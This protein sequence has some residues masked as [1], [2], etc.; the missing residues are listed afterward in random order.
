MSRLRASR[1][2][3]PVACFG[4]ISFYDTPHPWEK[5]PHLP[6]IHDAMK[7]RAA[8]LGY[9]I[10]PI[11]LR[12]PGMTYRRVRT[13]LKARGI[14]GLLCFGSPEVDQPFPEELDEFAIVTLGQ[15]IRTQLHR[16]TSHFFRDTWRT[17]E[18]VHAL[19]YRRP[20]LVL[21]HYD[22]MRSGHE[23]ASAYFGWCE[24]HLGSAAAMDILRVGRV[25]P[26]PLQAW[27]KAQRPD[28]LVF[29]H[30]A[31]AIPE[32]Q[33]SLKANRIRVPEDLGV[34]VVSQV[35]EQTRF[36]GMQQNQQLMGTWAVELLAG[37]IAHLDLGIPAHPRIE[38]VESEWLDR[39]SLPP[40]LRKS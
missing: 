13:I 14:Q 9:R 15:S 4:L 6:R 19:G 29:V 22:D 28:V 21:G 17:L 25:E 26:A 32:L 40:L 24:Q 36:S 1:V 31:G 5:L 30:L 20:G 34:A 16:V 3:G 10:E 2:D 18:R 35:I 38:L 33:A 11:W 39:G 37:R 12:A 8:E 27:L 23:C 7:Q